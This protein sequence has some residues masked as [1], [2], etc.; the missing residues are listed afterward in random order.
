SAHQVQAG[1]PVA[2]CL[3]R[4]VE[5]LVSILAVHAVGAYYIPLD[6]GYPAERIKYI[7]R[8]TGAR[9]V[10]SDAHTSIH[11]DYLQADPAIT[12]ILPDAATAVEVP[13][14]ELA[15]ASL[16][17]IAYMIYTSGSTGEPKGVVV[18]HA[19]VLNTLLALQ[20]RYP[21]K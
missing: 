18:E 5:M 8:D 20:E 11:L 13:G 4:S 10:L 19:Q 15:A 7:L 12:L 21:V 6:P 14:V 17:R 2:L 9:V 3:E 16:G 1:M